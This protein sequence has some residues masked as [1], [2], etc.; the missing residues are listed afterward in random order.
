[1]VNLTITP[2]SI[3]KPRLENLAQAPKVSFNIT[4]FLSGFSR[5]RNHFFGKPGKRRVSWSTTGNGTT[6]GLYHNDPNLQHSAL[7]FPD[8]ERPIQN[9]GKNM[10]EVR[11]ELEKMRTG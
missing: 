1:M 8:F 10:K 3:L 5:V 7:G 9:E 11:L 4:Y 6:G 2:A